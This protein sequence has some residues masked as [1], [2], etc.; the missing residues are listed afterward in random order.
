MLA[1]MLMLCINTN[2]KLSNT[3]PLPRNRPCRRDR[4]EETSPSNSNTGSSLSARHTD[5]EFEEAVT[6]LHSSPTLI[7]LIGFL[8]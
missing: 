7:C 6:G 3:E 5:R 1:L 2:R 8:F 4:S